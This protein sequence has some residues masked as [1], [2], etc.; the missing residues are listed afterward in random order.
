MPQSN[1]LVLVCIY[2][3]IKFI[4]DCMRYLTLNRLNIEL[5]WAK[6]K[7]NV[8]LNM[9]K[10]DRNIKYARKQKVFSIVLLNGDSS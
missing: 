5:D 8:F 2:K 1:R 4:S 9:D 6:V 7:E 10:G 3:Y